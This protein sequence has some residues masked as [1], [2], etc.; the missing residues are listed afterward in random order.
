MTAHGLF[1]RSLLAALLAGAVAAVP[2][3]AGDCV[4]EPVKAEID[5]VLTGDPQRAAEF[6]RLVGQGKDSFDM[7]L[8]LVP[9]A[10]RQPIDDCAYRTSEYLTDKGFP[11]LH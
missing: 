6:R 1:T 10:M 4:W 3:R 11:L 2:A 8:T 5:K 9:A 7:L